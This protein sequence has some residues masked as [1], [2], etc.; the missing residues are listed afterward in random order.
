MSRR[1]AFKHRWVFVLLV[2][3]VLSNASHAAA[4]G[5]G[6]HSHD[7]VTCTFGLNSDDDLGLPGTTVQTIE[8]IHVEERLPQLV[9]HIDASVDALLPPSTGPPNAG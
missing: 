1:F 9:R 5:S 7:G 2:A 8:R 3:A 4:F 6:P